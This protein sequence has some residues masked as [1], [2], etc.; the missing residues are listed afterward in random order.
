MSGKPT[1]K[2]TTRHGDKEFRL[3]AEEVARLTGNTFVFNE[4][5]NPSITIITDGG[6]MNQDVHSV[7]V[8]RDNYGHTGLTLANCSNI[9][10][11]H[12]P[13]A[14]RDLMEEVEHEVKKLIA[15]LPDEKKEIPAGD[16]EHLLK[17]ATASP[18]NRRWYEVSAS[19]LMEASGWFKD[20]TGNIAGSI[21]NL[22]KA[23]WPDF[24]LPDS[25]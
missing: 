21:R 20:F 8:G 16:L 25:E 24:S 15:A 2:V 3:I 13:G 17:G 22:G 23:I 11:Q 7:N 6:A 10:E 5:S 1:A 12:A 18:P 9:V 19:G 14:Q 4:G